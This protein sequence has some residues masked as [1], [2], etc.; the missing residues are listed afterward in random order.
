MVFLQ[1]YADGLGITNPLSVTA[2]DHQ[3]T[4]FYFSI[5][6]VPPKFN[7]SLSAIHLSACCSSQ[8]TKTQINLDAVLSAIISDIKKLE[9]TG[10]QV[11]VP[12]LGVI[13]VYA[14][15]GQFT[16]DNLALN[17]I[18]GLV[19]SFSH[20]YCCVLC[21][22]TRDEMQQKFRESM[23]ILRT[24]DSY[25]HDLSQLPSRDQNQV[26]VRGIKAPCVLNQSKYF[27]IM[28]NFINDC[29]HTVLEG[30]VPYVTSKVLEQ[31]IQDNLITLDEIN[32]LVQ[33]TFSKIKVDKKNKPRDL[34]I[35]SIPGRSKQISFKM[36]SAQT[37]AF[38][39]FLPFSIGHKLPYSKY[40][41]LILYLEE[42]VDLI[43]APSISE[44]TLFY[45][46]CIYE[47]FLESFKELFPNASI[48]PK[49]H[50]LIHFSSIVRH[51]GPMRTFWAMAFER[52]N[53]RFKN[54]SHSMN[55]FRNPLKT[56]SNKLQ[57]LSLYSKLC[58]NYEEEIEIV[59]SYQL[60]VADFPELNF[61]PYFV[62]QD[63]EFV[64]I[65][66][67]VT[68]CGTEYKKSYFVILE[69]IDQGYLFGKIDCIV[70]ED[71]HSPVFLLNLYTTIDFEQSCYCYKVERLSPAPPRFCFVNDFLDYHPLD[72]VER[73]GCTYIRLKYFVP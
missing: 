62:E 23:F 4:M 9:T 67:N 64:S 21:Y 19:Q 59:T 22:A 12:Q 61:Q 53:G 55:N 31:L 17:E 13:Q 68:I 50:F 48:R 15:L 36:T 70:C 25:N 56:L 60:N 38:F 66:N 71:P 40:F 8:E 29:M 33:Q 2:K 65:S 43:M 34:I 24:V 58:Y 32:D 51:N 6:N 3:S 7:A 11:D 35:T 39:R 57:C 10:I 26:H 49:M 42:I 30:V 27:H 20:D 69:K 14:T 47:K 63:Q 16:A 54:P 73:Q 5:L 41:E 44:T 18:F 46:E 28:E 1:F 37:W 52:M 45:F 72:S